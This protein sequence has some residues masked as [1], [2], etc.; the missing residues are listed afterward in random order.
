VAILIKYKFVSLPMYP[1]HRI[2][3]SLEFLLAIVKK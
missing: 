1:V 3:I 2:L